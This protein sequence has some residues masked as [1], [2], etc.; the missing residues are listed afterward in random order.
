MESKTGM[1]QDMTLEEKNET[2]QDL[3][4]CIKEAKRYFDNENDCFGVSLGCWTIEFNKGVRRPGD[5]RKMLLRPGN[6][7]A[8]REALEAIDKN[9]DLL[10]I[11]KDIAPQ[12]HPSHSFVAVQIRKIVR[13]ALAKPAR[14]CDL[15]LVDGSADRIADKV[16]LV[17]K[18]RNPD[19]YFDVFGLLRCIDWLLAPAMEQKGGADGSK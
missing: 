13:A 18:N 11:A 15:P 6:A 17:F 2:L 4:V 9:T 12:L 1:R 8:L 19:A 14:N 3:G 7:A 10:D 16:W 5:D